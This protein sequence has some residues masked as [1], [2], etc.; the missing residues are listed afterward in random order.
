ME[1]DYTMNFIEDLPELY[2]RD[3]KGKVRVWSIEVGYSNDDYAGTRTLAG[4]KDGKIV[5]SEW[6]LSEAKNVGKI[7]STNAYTQAQAEAKALWDKRIEKEY[8]INIS[9]LVAI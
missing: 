5:I 3:S 4:I 9:E 7:N 6:N 1:E 2:K 8:F